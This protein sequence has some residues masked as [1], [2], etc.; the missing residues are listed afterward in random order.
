MIQVFHNF[1]VSTWECFTNTTTCKSERERTSNN[2]QLQYKFY[3]ILLFNT[4]TNYKGKFLFSF[5]IER[6][7][8]KQ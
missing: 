6:C 3:F 8:N 4:F 1:V 5:S 7:N 2:F